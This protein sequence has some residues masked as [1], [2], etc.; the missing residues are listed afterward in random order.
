MDN[1]DKFIRDSLLE[2][3]AIPEAVEQKCKDAFESVRQNDSQPLKKKKYLAAKI[4][5]PIAA[6]IAIVF[7]FC[8]THPAFAAQIPVIKDIF[9]MFQTDQNLNDKDDLVKGD[10]GKYAKPVSEAASQAVSSEADSKKGIDL[11]V[12]QYSCDGTNLY[13]TYI[14]KVIDPKL[15]DCDGIEIDLY[16]QDIDKVNGQEIHSDTSLYLQRIKDGSF[17]AQQHFDLSQYPDLPEKFNLSI[18]IDSLIGINSKIQVSALRHSH[19]KIPAS[20]M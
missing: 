14:A 1:I 16:K 15:A 10:Q 19:F 6:S 17:V 2:D 5:L 18:R 12:Q 20:T 9:Q 4:C 11:K 3:N 13:V 7:G 8:F